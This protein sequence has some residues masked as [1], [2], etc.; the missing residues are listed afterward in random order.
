VVAR[1]IGGWRRG[2]DPQ[3]PIVGRYGAAPYRRDS[4]FALGLRV[5]TIGGATR[6]T[7]GLACCIEPL[8]GSLLS[9]TSSSRRAPATARGTAIVESDRACSRGQ[10]LACNTTSCLW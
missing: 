2:P 1:L 9:I 3:S 4:G 10:L 6:A 7:Y 5:P 8:V